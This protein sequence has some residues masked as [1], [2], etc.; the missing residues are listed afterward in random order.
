MA[1]VRSITF[2]VAGL[3]ALPGYEN[4]RVHCEETVELTEGDSADKVRGKLVARVER[5]VEEK[6]AKARADADRAR[7]RAERRERGH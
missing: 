1:R 5:L 6:L 3:V 4:V 2:G 7:R